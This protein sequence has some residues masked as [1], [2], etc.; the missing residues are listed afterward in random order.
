MPEA[1]APTIETLGD[2]ELLSDEFFEALAGL[3]LEIDDTSPRELIVQELHQRLSVA[4][5]KSTTARSK[6]A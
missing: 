1:P 6:K 2:P 4:V 3:L 5:A